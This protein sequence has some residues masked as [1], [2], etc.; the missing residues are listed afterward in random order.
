MTMIQTT[1][2]YRDLVEELG[3][4]ATYQRLAQEEYELEHPKPKP[5]AGRRGRKHP[6]TNG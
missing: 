6:R 3:D 5:P 1:P 4:P 2:I